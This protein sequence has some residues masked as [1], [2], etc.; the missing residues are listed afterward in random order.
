MEWQLLAEY[1]VEYTVLDLLKDI[2]ALHV[3]SGSSRR[4]V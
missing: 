1:T 4:R 2:S 3:G